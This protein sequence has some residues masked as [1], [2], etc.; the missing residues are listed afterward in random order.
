MENLW[1]K[2]KQSVKS[3]IP[4]HSFKMWIEPIEMVKYSHDNFTLS[5]P[6]FFSKKRVLDQ[7]GSLIET[8]IIKFLGKPCKFKVEVSSGAG[9]KKNI[10]KN[11]KSKKTKKSPIVKQLGL[12]NFNVCQSSGRILRKNF[13]FDQFVVSEGNKF[14]F[15][16]ALSL[17]SHKLDNHNALYLFSDTGLGKSHLSQAISHHIL[18]N[19]PSERVYYATAEDFTNEMVSSFKNNTFDQFKNKYRREC[20]VLLLE[21]VRF[22][23]GKERTQVELATAFDYLFDA[24]KK[25]IFTSS[26]LPSN[27]PKM[28]D[29]LRSRLS[30]GIITNIEK[31]DFKTRFKILKQKAGFSNYNMSNNIIEY[32]ASELTDNVRQLE[33]GLIG[34]GAKSTLLEVPVDM[35]LAESVVENI[36]RKKKTITIDYIKKVVCKNFNITV[37]DIISKSRKQKIV[38]PRQVAIYLS[39]KFTDQPLQTI[40]KNFNRKHATAI[41]SISTVERAIRE[42]K[43]IKDQVDYICNKIETEMM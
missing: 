19:Y 18:S 41:H 40:G 22:L 43:E 26:Y 38:R 37:A 32:L 17:A 6:N 23:T 20:D 29:Q 3:A 11:S 31:P 21:D 35:K 25:I 8:E 24:E 34:I 9:K 10:V 33:S 30:S 16:A 27:I 13:T 7:Y 2:V 5:C 36:A 28:S 14:A 4:E 1:G 42:K 39:R 15:S 12:P